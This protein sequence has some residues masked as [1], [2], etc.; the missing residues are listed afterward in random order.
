MKWDLF[1]IAMLTAMAAGGCAEW[2]EGAYMPATFTSDYAKIASCAKSAT[3]GGMY[4][5]TYV[6][7]K[8]EQEWKDNAVPYVKGTVF[9]KIGYDD[10]KCSD[11]PGKHWAMRKTAD[12]LGKWEWQML[13][14]DGVVEEEGQVGM[15]SGCHSGKEYADNDWV[16]TRP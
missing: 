4:V 5:E 9:A 3:H 14:G 11:A 2:D 1:S 16:A 15:C 10:S 12:E 8:H 7:K 6:Q 13:D